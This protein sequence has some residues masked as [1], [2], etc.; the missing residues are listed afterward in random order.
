MRTFFLLLFIFS[1]QNAAFSQENDECKQC[2]KR[3]VVCYDLSVL[4]PAPMTDQDSIPWKQLHEASVSYTQNILLKESPECLNVLPAC[5]IAN[6]IPPWK[7][8]CPYNG[9]QIRG[10]D[11]A[12]LGDI[13]GQEGSYSMHLMLVTNNH[14]IIAE[15]KVSFER[16]ADAKANGIVASLRLGGTSAGSKSL[17]EVIREYEKQ[18]RDESNEK[19]GG[20]YAIE[21][22]IEFEKETYQFQYKLFTDMSN[23][24]SITLT[25]CDG[26]PLKKREVTVSV[27]KGEIAEKKV[28]TDENGQA[29]VTYLITSNEQYNDVITAEWEFYRPSEKQG[30]VRKAA[31]IKVTKPILFLGGEITIIKKATTYI[32]AK[33]DQRSSSTQ[34]IVINSKL[35]FEIIR[36]RIQQYIENP[37]IRNDCGPATHCPVLKGS[38]NEIVRDPDDFSKLLKD[39]RHPLM[40]GIDYW[41][42][43]YKKVGNSEKYV[44]TTSK[45]AEG[46]NVFESLTLEIKTYVPSAGQLGTLVPQYVIWLTGNKYLDKLREYPIGNGK[47]FTWD[48]Y[49]ESLV[50]VENPITIGIPYLFSDPGHIPQPNSIYEQLLITN[51]KEFERYLLNPVGSFTIQ[52]SGRRYSLSDNLETEEEISVTILL[53]PNL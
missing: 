35:K 32:P 17:N 51:T 3:F 25:D 18:K 20:I 27:Q 9:E 22:R 14:R 34:N 24:I 13:K 4:I 42:M 37:A 28:F 21:P 48:N 53:N 8:P 44:R 33:K 38:S 7:M 36:S 5:R 2:G 47:E 12:L 26:V 52:A 1:M 40:V 10:Y 29:E 19:E 15:T 23:K 16:A 41:D 6:D 43:G 11:Y 50:P 46:A 31:S 39:T 49:K 45:I 30:V